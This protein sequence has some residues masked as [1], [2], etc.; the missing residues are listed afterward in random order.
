MKSILS[1]IMIGLI[2]IFP[3]F[4]GLTALSTD[5]LLAVREE[6]VERGGHNVNRQN[7]NRSQYGHVH[8]NNPNV[9]RAYNPNAAAAARGYEAGAV[10]NQGSTVI[11]TP[12]TSNQ[13]AP[14]TPSSQPAPVNP[15]ATQ[16]K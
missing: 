13:P 2:A 12:G 6:R 8:Q 9:N 15:S 11:L 5:N 14:V 3:F 7:V 16:G 1:K 4:M 10:Q